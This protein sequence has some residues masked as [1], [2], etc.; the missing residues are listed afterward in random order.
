GI[1]SYHLEKD[2]SQVCQVLK[3]F[4][5]NKLFSK[6]CQTKD[7]SAK[8]L[9]SRNSNCSSDLWTQTHDAQTH[10][11]KYVVEIQIIVRR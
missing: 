7:K 11:C 9:T 5:S 4:C 2:P 6:T 8:G 10:D 3:C 1:F